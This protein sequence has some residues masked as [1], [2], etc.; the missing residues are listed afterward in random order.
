MPESPLYVVIIAGGRGTR[1]WPWSRR[2]RPK[3]C[4]S[5]DGGASLLQ[6]TLQRVTPLVPPEH[7]LVVTAADMAAQVAEQLPEL[8]AEN[9]LVEPM[10]R[11]TAPAVG[12]AA[13]EI[14]HR[15]HGRNPVMVVLPADHAVEDEAELR[16][17]LVS[18]AEAARQTNALITLGISPTR[19]ET[20]FGYLQ[21]GPPVARFA[22]REARDVRRFVEKPDLATAQRYLVEGGYLWNA[23]MFVF[24]VEAIRDAFRQHLPHTWTRLEALRHSPER[25]EELYGQL[26]RV[27]IDVGIM[28]KAGHV[29]TF[30][31]ALGWSD[32]G[33]W[34][35]LAEHLPE[36]ALGRARVKHGVSVD[37]RDNLVVAPDKV[38]ALVGVEGLVVVDT[39]DA[40]LIVPRAQ[41]QRV[42]EA[43][44]ALEAE[45][46]DEVL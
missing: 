3:Q 24:T 38:V 39:G 26:D 42:R 14:G 8:P 9:L 33:T 11:N 20:G 15:E 31:A 32:L 29:M 18:A 36:H 13:S 22:G 25:L 46:A 23:G 5:I 40:L 21:V 16:A 6:R 19:P 4:L 17:L 44:A 10:G 7:V 12:W 27:S 37:A 41:V 28:E 2:S 34:E 45:G 30:P 35:A 43:I 1:F